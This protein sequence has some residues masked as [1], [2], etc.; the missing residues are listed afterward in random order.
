MVKINNLPPTTQA[1]T[2]SGLVVQALGWI[3]SWIDSDLVVKAI[4]ADFLAWN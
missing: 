4:A 3:T 2:S 1:W